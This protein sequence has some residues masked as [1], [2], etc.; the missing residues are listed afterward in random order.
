MI[1]LILNIIKHTNNDGN[2][3]ERKSDDDIRKLI[4]R[5]DYFLRCQSFSSFQN[6]YEISVDKKKEKKESSKL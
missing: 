1:S 3:T 5:F 6:F 4:H 2:S